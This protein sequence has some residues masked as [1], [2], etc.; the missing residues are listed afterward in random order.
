MRKIPVLVACAAFALGCGFVSSAVAKPE[1]SIKTEHYNISGDTGLKLL[2]AMNRKGPKHGWWARSIAQTQYTTSWG[3]SWRWQNG[4]C[5]AYKAPVELSITYVYPKLTG[6]QSNTLRKRWRTFLA[7]VTVHE[8]VHG[9]L[10]R[11]MAYAVEKEILSTRMKTSD[12]NCR[13]MKKRLSQRVGKVLKAYEAKQASF[14]K[15]EHRDGG[16]VDRMVNSLIGK[17]S[18]TA[19]VRKKTNKKAATRSSSNTPATLTDQ[20]R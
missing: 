3:A 2:V 1:I 20:Y 12:V 6:K 7:K 4:S 5:R 14:D 10:A 19:A 13:G 18:K 8:K 15:V 16:N 9:K 11:Q 17:K